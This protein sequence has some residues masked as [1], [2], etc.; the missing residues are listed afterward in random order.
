MLRGLGLHGS[1]TI[2][3]D[4][5]L[6]NA[7]KEYGSCTKCTSWGQIFSKLVSWQ[8]FGS[9]QS[10]P[11]NSTSSVLGDWLETLMPSNLCNAFIIPTPSGCGTPESQ[12]R[13]SNH[14]R[15]TTMDDSSFISVPLTSIVCKL[16]TSTLQFIYEDHVSLHNVSSSTSMQISSLDVPDG[17]LV[18]PCS[19]VSPK[20][21]HAEVHQRMEAIEIASKHWKHQGHENIS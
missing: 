14:A 10:A 12:N 5:F 8:R 11:S 20:H 2:F 3:M 9:W 16:N 17:A 18:V 21:A 19:F 13:L 7:I 1:I 4:A 6:V 15:W